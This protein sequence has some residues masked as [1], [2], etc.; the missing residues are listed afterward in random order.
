MSVL[1]A[2]APARGRGALTWLRVGICLALAAIA[3]LLLSATPAGAIRLDP[4]AY[5]LHPLAFIGDAA[6][7]GGTFNFD[8]EPSVI[9][10]QG[11]VAFT[12]DVSTGGE[13]VFTAKNGHLTQITRSGLP[14][15]GGV[16]MG[17]AG[18]LGRLGLSDGGDVAIAFILESSDSTL[19]PGLPGGVFRFSHSTN[20]L[21]AVAV[22]G[23]P[24]PGGGTFAGSYYNVGMNNR[25]DIVF[26]GLA[27]G[28]A[29]GSPGIPPNYSG[30]SLAL[31]EQ[32]KDGTLTR[33]AGPGDAAPG[34]HV[35]DDAWNGSINNRGDIAFSG[36]VVGDPCVILVA[37][38]FGCGDSLYL[39]D[40]ATGAIRSIA[41]QG[42]PA[43]GGGT[44]VVAFG[45]L[46]NDS[47]QVAFLG[48]LGSAATFT[49]DGVYRYANG[50]LSAVAVPGDSMPGGGEL[51]SASGGVPA[52]GINNR[53]DISFAAALNTDTTGDGL[54]DT[55]VY[56]ASHGAIRLVAR[57]GT[58]IP[59]VG[60]I[61]QLGQFVNPP[62]NNPPAFG[63]GGML[64]DRGQVLFNA[65][66]TDGTGVLLVAT[67]AGQ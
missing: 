27:T 47:R 16:T 20:A 59:G 14:G 5:T 35:F 32:G 62:M 22:P 8:F 9:N 30:M 18:E 17:A 19:P 1:L 63:T 52:E 24:A 12:A 61:S 15:P 34:G 56:V 39:R 50:V 60:T 65:T 29:I 55:G 40:S 25:G 42:D 66:L 43:P 46:V 6:P 41:H 53:G 49:P 48:G 44:F 38:P 13:G 58:V 57:S 36:H 23:T 45:G 10:A 21:S 54:N 33:V 37:N 28:S 67:P 3:I 31:F 51:A 7:G 26:P 2:A 64:N 11:E 4:G